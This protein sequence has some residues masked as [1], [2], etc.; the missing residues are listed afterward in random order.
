MRQRIFAA[1]QTGGNRMNFTAFKDT[2]N[3]YKGNIHSHTTNSDGK[4]RPEQSVK[5]YKSYGYNFLCFTEHD[6]YTD[7]RKK[8][9]TDDFIIIPGIEASVYFINF[10]TKS[11]EKLHH[12]NGILGTSEMQA[13]APRGLFKHRQRLIPRIVYKEW[14]GAEEAE[15]LAEKLYSHGCLVMYN[16]PVW[17]RAEPEEFMHTKNLWALEVFNYNTENECSLGIDTRDWDTMLGKNTFILGAATDDNH[18]SGE[19]DDAC[20]GYIMV[21]A[22]ELTHD[23]IVSSMLKGCF[24]SSSGPGIYN[25]GIDRNTAWIDCS[26]CA[27]INFICGGPVGVGR[28][29]LPDMPGGKIIHA[30]HRMKGTETYL[31]IECVDSAGG[32]AWTNPVM[33]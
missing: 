17:S 2:G 8:F 9:N 16:H 32:T 24:Y 31:R 28:T 29:Y 15:R 12:M 19:F 1:R 33:M 30:E 3:W 13:A 10:K 26:A 4:L 14:N 18:N 20:G 5:L 6:R 27:R 23:S 22:D 25:W 21:Q 7:Y 11:I